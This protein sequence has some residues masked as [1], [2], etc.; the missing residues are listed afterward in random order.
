VL[1]FFSPRAL[2]RTQGGADPGTWLWKAGQGSRWGGGRVDMIRN[3]F[4][5]DV[6]GSIPRC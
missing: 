5:T 6:Q 3:T 1:A 2:S 4:R